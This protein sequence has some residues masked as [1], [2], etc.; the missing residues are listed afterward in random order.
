MRKYPYICTVNRDFN[1]FFSGKT[2][3]YLKFLQNRLDEWEKVRIFAPEMNVTHDCNGTA[4]RN[5]WS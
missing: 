3:I 2:L 1:T 5:P 4:G